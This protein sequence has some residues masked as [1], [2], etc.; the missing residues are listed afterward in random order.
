M[1]WVRIYSIDSWKENDAIMVA[2]TYCPAAVAAALANAPWYRGEGPISIIRSRSL[3]SPSAPSTC[4][5]V[6]L[7]SIG[8]R[9]MRHIPAETLPAAVL[10]E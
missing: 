6:L 10:Y 7:V 8:M 3:F 4:I 1:L 2:V 5:T 9:T